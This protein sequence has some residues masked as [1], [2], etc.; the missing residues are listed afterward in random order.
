M[1]HYRFYLGYLKVVIKMALQSN[2]LGV[3]CEILQF[4]PSE[5]TYLHSG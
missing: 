5:L 3:V 2:F 4:F 1:R